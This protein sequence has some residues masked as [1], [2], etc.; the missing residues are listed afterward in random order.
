MSPNS[1]NGGS[2]NTDEKNNGRKNDAFLT[3]LG[4]R[5]P[6]LPRIVS[7][8]KSDNHCHHHQHHHYHHYH[9]QSPLNE[10]SDSHR[11]DEYP[12][13]PHPVKKSGGVNETEVKY[14]S[15]SIFALN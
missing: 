15:A 6:S 11:W 14:N 4:C 2:G 13:L 9:Y 12:V 3:R 5:I 7:G 10:H 8:K 1:G